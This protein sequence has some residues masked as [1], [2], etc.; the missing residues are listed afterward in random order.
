MY[1][2]HAPPTTMHS[3]RSSVGIA[4]MP[5]CNKKNRWTAQLDKFKYTPGLVV[6]NLDLDQDPSSSRWS[7][8][9]RPHPLEQGKRGCRRAIQRPACPP[10][11]LSMFCCG[12]LT[13]SH[14]CTYTHHLCQGFLDYFSPGGGVGGK[15]QDS[16]VKAACTIY[17]WS[18]D[19]PPM[20][21][22]SR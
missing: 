20:A 3:L 14:E 15:V 5:D 8:R 7:R 17:P 6:S 19:L 21:Q 16:L 9:T 11:T 22:V 2:V 10:R 4:L 12:T 1:P 18:P 13:L